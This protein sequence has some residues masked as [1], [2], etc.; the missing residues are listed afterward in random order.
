MH[1]VCAGVRKD[2]NGIEGS[3][4]ISSS[5]AGSQ[6]KVV[7]AKTLKKTK[8]T[9]SRAAETSSSYA[10]GKERAADETARR[11]RIMAA[12]TAD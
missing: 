6:K 7:R 3:V 11:G 12:R 8:E 5:K 1:P 4:E 10:V 9:R 2:G